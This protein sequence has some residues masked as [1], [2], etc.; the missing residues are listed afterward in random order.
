MAEC[1][2]VHK[3]CTMVASQSVEILWFVRHQSS[4]E[5]QSTFNFDEVLISSIADLHPAC[6]VANGFDD[7]GTKSYTSSL[8]FLSCFSITNPETFFSMILHIDKGLSFEIVEIKV[9]AKV[10]RLLCTMIHPKEHSTSHIYTC[11]QSLLISIY[12]STSKHI[13]DSEF[14]FSRSAGL[15][16][17]WMRKCSC[18]AEKTKDMPVIKTVEKIR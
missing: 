8:A 5:L 1:S 18:Q 10:K 16:V 17:K 2:L 14:V 4:E 12:S 6:F 15:K 9:C 13:F 7:G 3:C 11:L